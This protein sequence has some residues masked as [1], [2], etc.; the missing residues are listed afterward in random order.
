MGEVVVLITAGSSEE[1]RK[2]G[3]CLVGAGLAAC[4]NIVPTVRSIFRWE[5]QVTEE[6]ETLVIVK[7]VSESFDSLEAMVKANHSYSVP[8]II[9][10]PIEAGSDSYLSWVREMTQKEPGPIQQS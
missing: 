9:A 1:A 4:A 3:H 10:L 2:I 7:T 5:G 6:E 8:E